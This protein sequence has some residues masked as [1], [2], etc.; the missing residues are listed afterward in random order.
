M[1]A[2][3]T[4]T[5]MRLIGVLWMMVVMVPPLGAAPTH[6]VSEEPVSVEKLGDGGWLVDF[7]KVTFGNL[8]IAAPEGMSG[9]VEVRFGEA[10]KDGRVDRKPPGTVRYAEVRQHLIG[11]QSL[12]VAPPA[13]ARNTKQPE[14]ILTPPEWGVLFP[15]R[16]VE[17]HGW[18]GD[19]TLQ[20]VLR[21]SV[22][23]ESW[24]DEAASFECSDP[25]IQR[26]W[27]LCRDSIKATSFAGIYVDGDRE[28]IPYEADAYLNQLSHYATD[29]DVEMARDTFDHLLRHPT[30]PSEWGPHMVFMAYADWMHTGDREGLAQRY[31]AVKSKLLMERVG[32]DGWVTSNEKQRSWNDIVDWPQGERDGFEHREVNT[33]VNAF[34]LRAVQL[35]GEMARA[36]GKEQ[37]AM[38]YES[39]FEERKQ[40]FQEAF[41]LHGR[42]AYRDGVGSNHASLHASMFPLAFG[43]VPESEQDAV[44]EMLVDRGMKC[45]VYGAQYLLEG[46]FQAGRGDAGLGLMTAK[47]DRSWRHMVESGTT[48]TWEAWDQKYK[49]NQD[50]NHAWGAAPANL[51]PRFILGVEPA[52]PGWSVVRMAP[53][54]CG[55]NEAKGKV[56]TPRGPVEVH[57]KKTGTSY[58]LKFSLP[59]GMK[60]RVL[61]PYRGS[62]KV[63]KEEVPLPTRREGKWIRVVPEQEGAG[64][65]L[66]R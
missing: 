39:R 52:E 53:V 43:L 54:P 56:P 24:N 19:L 66:L 1:I 42:G 10:L 51:L 21:N 47:G 17:L 9:V 46:L 35:M 25:L 60:A 32:P 23:L 64:T 18:K 30:W 41:F 2:C 49:P 13:D 44:A 57:W 22:F 28:R 61:L 59:E 38:A 12:R 62:G 48:V 37:E 45:S 20:N 3:G 6:V 15:F 14:A 11:G 33:V 8:Q 27:G 63:S 5:V 29:T 16:W 34:H 4:R 55:L 36:L 50:W 26:I 65:L 7:G 58:G 31:E 40:A